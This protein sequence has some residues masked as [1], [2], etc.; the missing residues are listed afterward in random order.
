MHPHTLFAFLN[1]LKN[2]FITTIRYK[3]NEV[4]VEQ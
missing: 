1:L 4:S 2:V 3:G